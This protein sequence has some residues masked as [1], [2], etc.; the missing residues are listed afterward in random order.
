MAGEEWGIRF[1][2]LLG[3]YVLVAVVALVVLALAGG[4]LTFSAYAET[5]TRTETVQTASWESTGEFTHRATVVNGTAVYDQG[6]I[7]R[8]RTNYFKAI[9]PRLNGTFEYTY[10]ASEG[11]NLTVNASVVATL[12]SARVRAGNVTEYW[13]LESTLGNR[14]VESLSSGETME[15]PFSIN[16][17][18]AGIRLQEIDEQFG[19][20]PGQKEL[21]IETRIRLSGT[22]NGRS[23]ETTRVYELPVSISGNIYEVGD[24]GPVTHSGS[25]TGQ[26]TVTV[27]PGPLEAYGGPAL[28]MVA[29]V[30]AAGLGGARYR[31]SLSVSEREREW[32]T[33]RNHRAEFGDWITVARIPEDE[34]HA[35]TV[36]VDALEGLVNIAIDSDRHVF[37]DRDRHQY[38][39]FE[40]DRTYVYNP[41]PSPDGGL[42]PGIEGA[43]S[44]GDTPGDTSEDLSE[45]D[46]DGNSAPVEGIEGI[47]PGSAEALAAGGIETT[48][49]LAAADAEEV[50]EVADVSPD[51][52]SDWIERA[53]NGT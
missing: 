37:E 30:A 20:T 29:I 26:R 42:L 46:S 40:D 23:V 47:D 48:T 49:D 33:Y 5:D 43:R 34:H 3:E 31:G 9:N 1:R 41:P 13:R 51:R 25:Q 52:A 8:N 24:P 27:E 4:Y 36:E 44:D 7:L 10:A 19:G 32:L 17:T 50:A 2:S 21:T 18:A 38:L 14:E 11:G 6:E 28:L 53:R 16:V 35:R 22:R 15:V 45:A 39:V 12:R